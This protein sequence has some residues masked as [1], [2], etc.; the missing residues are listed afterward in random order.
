[1]ITTSC[2]L[3]DNFEILEEPNPKCKNSKCD[4]LKTGDIL[5]DKVDPDD[6]DE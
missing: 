3:D 4:E 5:D 1:M 2:S 6:D